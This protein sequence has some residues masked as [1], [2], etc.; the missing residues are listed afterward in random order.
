MTLFKFFKLDSTT[1]QK[2]DTQFFSV[3]AD[4][5]DGLAVGSVIENFDR[6]D[7]VYLHYMIVSIEE[8]HPEVRIYGTLHP[9][10]NLQHPVIN[11]RGLPK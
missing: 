11:L 2:P 6:Q 7:G 1:M 3:Q 8:K 10:I 4:K 9:V 5:I